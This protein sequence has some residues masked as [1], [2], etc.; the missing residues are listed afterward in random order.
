MKVVRVVHGRA[1]A[2]WLPARFNFALFRLFALLRVKTSRPEP[3]DVAL[4]VD[5]HQSVVEYFT[6]SAWIFLTVACWIAPV[7]PKGWPLVVS[8]LV[9][10]P[11][12]NLALQ[13][14]IAVVGTMLV[15]LWNVVTRRR[16]RDPMRVQSVAQMTILI[17]VAAAL[18]RTGT[19]ARL[20]AWQFLAVVALNAIASA[21][22]FLM[23]RPMEEAERAV[24]GISSEL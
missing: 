8:V 15:P 12:A 14:P 13:A 20:A 6:V 19:W 22:V 7:F 21:I 11:L 5:R 4:V 3:R 17:V 16:V 24:G 9:A 10:L 23:R 2:R 18:T 1:D